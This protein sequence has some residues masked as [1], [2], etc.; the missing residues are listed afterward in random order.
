MKRAIIYLRP[1]HPTSYETEERKALEED[2]YDVRTRNARQF[3]GVPDP[4]E[5]VVTDVDAIKRAYESASTD[6]R[7]FE[8]KAEASPKGKPEPETAA[9]KARA[10]AAEVKAEVNAAPGTDAGEAA[11]QTKASKSSKSKK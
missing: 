5:L 2:G 3:S 1:D 8:V 9:D 7:G 10:I 4:C 11:E 6:V